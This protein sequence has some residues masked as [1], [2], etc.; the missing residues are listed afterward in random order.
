[1]SV[2]E[3]QRHQ[4]LQWLEEVMGPERAA[5]MME[6]LPPVG[7]GDIATNADLGELRTEMQSEIRARFADVRGEIQALRGEM[8]ADR[9]DLLMKLFFGMVASNA[10]LVGLG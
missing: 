2:T 8:H 9:A 3:F 4:I 5:V 7:W 10:T 1:M 6:L